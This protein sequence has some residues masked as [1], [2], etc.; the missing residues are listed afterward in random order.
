M[1]PERSRRRWSEVGVADLD[2]EAHGLVRRSGMDADRT[3]DLVEDIIEGLAH[4][5]VA[6]SVPAFAV[7]R[8]DDGSVLEVDLGDPGLVYV[9]SVTS[10]ERVD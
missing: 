3:W 2:L 9:V 5:D 4:G 7:E 6:D 10:V 1:E 8:R